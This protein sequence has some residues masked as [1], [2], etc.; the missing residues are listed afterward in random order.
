MVKENICQECSQKES[1][2][3]AFEKLGNSKGPSVVIKSILAF[4]VPLVI[5]IAALAVSEK[6]F[7]KNAGIS[8]LLAAV[9]T[10][11]YILI[12]WSVNKHL[13]K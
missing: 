9:L 2:R 3:Q 8:F 12:V 1:C 13:K 5:F 10:A 4:L 11:I 6:I 7:Q